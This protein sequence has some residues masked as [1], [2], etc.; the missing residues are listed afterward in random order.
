MGLK[1]HHDEKEHHK[2]LQYL[3]RGLQ[4]L[5]LSTMVAGFMACGT[6]GYQ[7]WKLFHNPYRQAAR[8]AEAPSIAAADW[9]AEVYRQEKA[10][11]LLFTGLFEAGLIVV[12]ASS[13]FGYRRVDRHLQQL[14][15]AR[16]PEPQRTK[17]PP[18]P[19]APPTAPTT[20][21]TPPAPTAPA[22]QP[23]AQA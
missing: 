5:C 9:A 8:R 14:I 4:T 2:G 16:Q 18:P 22:P 1:P 10:D 17:V 13:W 19:A 6:F 12:S 23:T 7:G 15:R 21:T 20:P 11:H 3:K